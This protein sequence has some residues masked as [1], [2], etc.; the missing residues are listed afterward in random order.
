MRC[1]GVG[2]KLF[3]ELLPLLSRQGFNAA[4]AGIALPN[5]GNVGL[6]ERLVFCHSGTF[7]SVG[8]KLGMRHDVGDRCLEFDAR[9]SSPSEPRLHPDIAS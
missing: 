1:T 2:R 4:Y 6:H 3:G 7:P 8:K 9:N 5:S